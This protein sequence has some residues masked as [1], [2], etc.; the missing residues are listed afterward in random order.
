M[1]GFM[2]LWPYLCV[3]VEQHEGS[4]LFRIDQLGVTEIVRREL[5]GCLLPAVVRTIQLT[6]AQTGT[7]SFSKG[8][9]RDALNAVGW[10]LRAKAEHLFI[11]TE[12]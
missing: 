3:K 11:M 6:I 12:P 1:Y 5:E 8:K 4:W 9:R 2:C 10:L 7:E